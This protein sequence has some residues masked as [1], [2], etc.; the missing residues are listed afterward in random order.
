MNSFEII[1]SIVLLIGLGYSMKSLNLLSPSDS[2]PLTT[3]VIN[4]TLPATIFTAMLGNIQA[5][6]L[7]GY[8]KCTII[9]LIVSIICV[10]I[11]YIIGNSLKMNKK[12]LYAF[13]LI[14]SV[15]STAFMGY[16][17][18]TGYF[19]GDGLI[20]AIF[21]DASTF[22]VLGTISTILGLKL[23]GKKANLLTSILKFPPVTTWLIS[24]G[25][26]CLGF[27]LSKFPY[28]IVYP[29]KLISLATT[30]LIMFSVGLSLSPKSIKECFKYGLI[31]TMIR[32][33]IAP[34]SAFSL[35]NLF[36]LSGLDKQVT[37]LQASMPPALAPVSIAEVWGM[38]T[39]LVATS[40][41][42]A[43]IISMITIPFIHTL[44]TTF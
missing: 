13:M 22:M 10:G 34:A 5:S 28:V 8:L 15:G 3:L 29:L 6:D 37:I 23:T 39:K 41:F 42:I 32:L 2:K 35:T 19:G 1:I 14:C 38:D 11:A 24:M 27:S 4:V 26:I 43:T 40:I 36:G 33:L 25:L 17:I 30:P 9:T 16:P 18:V 44:I 12:S 21:C 20:R 7:A 31:V